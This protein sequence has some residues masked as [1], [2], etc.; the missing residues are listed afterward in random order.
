MESFKNIHAGERCFILGNGPSL[1][2]VNLGALEN[3]VV[4]GTNRIYLSNYT[5]TYYVCVNDLVLEQ[6]WKEINYIDTVKFIARKPAVKDVKETRAGEVHWLDTSLYTPSF[7]S[8]DGPIWEGHTVTYVALQLAYY[9]GF[10]EVILL[11]LDHYYGQVLHPDMEVLAT[12][13]DDNHF[14]PEYFAHGT[15]WHAP[16]LQQSELAYSLAKSYFERDQRRI[17][18]CSHRTKLDVFERVS[19]NH[20]ITG[21]HYRVSA[22]VSA[23]KAEKFAQACLDDLALQTEDIEVIWVCEDGSFE[24]KIA[25]QY[26]GKLHIGIVE[27]NCIPTVYQAWNLGVEY[28]SGRYLTNANTDDRHHPLAYEIMAYVLDGRD[29]IDLVYHDSFITWKDNQTFDEFLDEGHRWEDLS[30]YVEEGKAGIWCWNEYSRDDLGIGCYMGPHPMWRASLHQKYGNFLAH[31]V[32]A[33]DYEF[34]LRISKESNMYH[35]PHT[36]GLYLARADSVEH[37]NSLKSTQESHAALT[38]HQSK[39][40]DIRPR[41][42]MVRVAMNGGWCYLDKEALLRTV[43][44]VTEK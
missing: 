36:L 29:E 3:Q 40:V 6:F 24:H 31:Y 27:T 20:F 22:I 11:G 12:G 8:P 34:W 5:P 33:G 14:D 35:I 38:L 19:Y 41:G 18:N 28:A 32:T 16:N 17:I 42:D 23:Y 10:E 30:P 9:M 25:K 13:Y 43:Q 26:E 39:Y 37:T 2:K 44:K 7:S 1:E 15:R 4:F 21:G